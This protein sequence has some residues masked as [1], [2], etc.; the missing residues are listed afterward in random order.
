MSTRWQPVRGRT[1]ADNRRA[2]DV[3]IEATDDHSAL[4]GAHV[5]RPLTVSEYPPTDTTATFNNLRSNAPLFG[6][7]YVRDAVF[8]CKAT[9]SQLKTIVASAPQHL[10]SHLPANPTKDTL[11]ETVLS[12]RTEEALQAR[13]NKRSPT[14]CLR[15]L[16]DLTPSQLKALANSG[17]SQLAELMR[18]AL[19]ADTHLQ[20]R[21][22]PSTAQEKVTTVLSWQLEAQKAAHATP[23]I[24][25]PPP[26]ASPSANYPDLAP[27]PPTQ[28]MGHTE[29]PRQ[30][31]NP[32]SLPIALEEIL[33]TLQTGS[34]APHPSFPRDNDSDDDDWYRSGKN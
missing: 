34:G 4:Q 15:E 2:T 18:A 21:D 5:V 25:P 33:A 32:R 26:L 19:L 16:V 27:Q 8:Y 20:P 6:S 17:P 30:T 31:G 3:H 24:P 7:L 22:I 12:F 11:L 14:E 23:D 29:I 28:R 9:I 1:V 13:L 10:R